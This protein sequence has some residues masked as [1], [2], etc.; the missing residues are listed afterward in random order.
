MR[1]ATIRDR[2]ARLERAHE[3]K[4]LSVT[5]AFA[6]RPGRVTMRSWPVRPM[7]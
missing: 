5:G 2:L 6:A 7:T 1:L 3:P 4:P